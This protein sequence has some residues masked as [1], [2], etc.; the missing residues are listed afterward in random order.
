MILKH[1]TLLFSLILILAASSILLI[2]VVNVPLKKAVTYPVT[3]TNTSL[4]TTIAVVTTSV[5]I[6]G[7]QQSPNRLSFVGNTTFQMSM[8]FQCSQDKIIIT[9]LQNVTFTIENP[10]QFEVRDVEVRIRFSVPTRLAGKSDYTFNYVVD[11]IKSKETKT[12]HT[13]AFALDEPLEIPTWS[14][15]ICVPDFH[16]AKLA[17]VIVSYVGPV[18]V[19]QQY[20]YTITQTM[21]RTVDTVGPVPLWQTIGTGGTTTIL[22]AAIALAIGV[23]VLGDRRKLVRASSRI[24]VFCVECGAENSRTSEICHECGSKLVKP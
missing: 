19:T 24:P 20:T 13:A 22:V 6:G 23:Y 18:E 21:T 8:I 16:D 11:L 5:S 4:S 7:E 9:S 1:A 17:V 10:T 14:S 15:I 3:M 2:P 12:I